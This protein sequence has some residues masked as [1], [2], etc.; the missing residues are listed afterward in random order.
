MYLCVV[1]PVCMYVS[2]LFLI[3]PPDS[4]KN[5]KKESKLEFLTG[6][7]ELLWGNCTV[8]PVPVQGILTGGT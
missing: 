8:F 4:P 1:V 6:G 7:V 2:L 5:L 3:E